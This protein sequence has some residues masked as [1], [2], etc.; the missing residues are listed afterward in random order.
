[1]IEVSNTELLELKN[2]NSLVVGEVYH[3]T[4]YGGTLQIYMGA[5]SSSEFD[6][7]STSDNP[8]IYIHYL[9]EENSIDYMKDVERRIEGYFDW[10][11][12]VS[13]NCKDVYFENSRD[14]KVI[15]SSEI[16]CSGEVSGTISNSKNIMMENGATVTIDNSQNIVVGEGSTINISGCNNLTIGEQN[17]FSIDNIEGISVGDNNENLKLNSYNIVWSGNF[18]INVTGENNVIFNG[19]REVNLVGDFNSLENSRYIELD[20]SFNSLRNSE[21]IGFKESVGN[22]VDNSYSVDVIKSNN[23]SISTKNLVI[24]GKTPFVSYKSDKNS[25][26]KVV[27]NLV[28]P[29]NLQS[30]NR[31]RVLDLNQQRFF[32]EV[33]EDGLKNVNSFKLDNGIW[34]KK[35]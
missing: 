10:T 1:M 35:V 6:D 13:G 27:K 18:E 4:N 22:E 9:L 21:L 19:N 17:I 2:S 12:N 23:S 20:G 3:I 14:L 28:E 25:E 5:I 32:N 16:Y 31:G 11:D 33:G 34:V 30:D 15:D 26:I 8:N 7:E 24:E 29:E